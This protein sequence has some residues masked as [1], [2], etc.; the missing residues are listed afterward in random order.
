WLEDA[1]NPAVEDWLVQ[2]HQ[3]CEDYVGRD[4]AEWQ[5]VRDYVKKLPLYETDYFALAIAGDRCVY[6]MQ[7]PG[8]EQVNIYML[9]LAGGEPRLLIDPKTDIV[10]TGW[11]IQE[12]CL[13]ISPCG[14]YLAF[15]TNH[16]GSDI[17][18]FRIFDMQEKQLLDDRISGLVSAPVSWKAD[19]SGFYYGAFR[20]L[21]GE[22]PTADGLYFH[23]LGRDE[24]KDVCLLE[25]T[26]AEQADYLAIMP[27]VIPGGDKIL[28]MR[29]SYRHLAAGLWLMSPDHDDPVQVLF[30]DYEAD[31]SVVGV[32]GGQL[33]LSTTWDA[34]KGRILSI[35]LAAPAR[36]NW[37]EIIAPQALS[38]AKSF[39]GVLDNRCCLCGDRLLVTY[40]CDAKHRVV[41]FDLEGQEVG[42]VPLGGPATVIGLR[43]C[44]GSQYILSI[45]SFLEPLSL[46]QMDMGNEEKK[47]LVN[48]KLQDDLKDIE[49]QQ[50]FYQAD[51]GQK[52]PLY[53][54]GRDI[55]DR[56]EPKPV[57]LY[58]YGG[59][60][61]AITPVFNPDV[62]LWLNM[63]GTYALANIRGGGEYG[64]DWHEAAR[65]IKRNVSFNDFRAAADY[66]TSE[67][68]TDRDHLAI[69]GLS[70][71]G[72]LVGASVV[73]YP[74]K[75]AAAIAEVPLLD[76]IQMVQHA[77]AEVLCKE[78]GDLTHDPDV[79]DTVLKYSPVQNVRN[80]VDYPAVMTVPAREAHTAPPVQSWKFIAALQNHNPQGRPALLNMVS[81]EGHT[82]W[83][84]DNMATAMADE[85]MFLRRTVIDVKPFGKA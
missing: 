19:S 83:S 79:L 6:A 40:M 61:Q 44:S 27:W 85:M 57:L 54:I 60:D 24:T 42:E 22:S 78:Y 70:N 74:E 7:A 80:D 2:Q 18:D 65:G 73:L 16:N 39:P 33:Y 12:G 50:V 77:G 26:E 21:L 35:P 13:E 58:G 68:I 82:N 14:R 48:F 81:G 17:S 5:T 37:R 69:R 47:P 38:I 36:E 20:S 72:L 1:T 84:T 25:L 31:F 71:G 3:L 9:T 4:K 59:F 11:R 23:T 15:A 53:L 32:S 43:P 66:L 30:E 49:V 46:F 52:I 45:T 56:C 64:K 34:E 28:V 75:W 55:D 76:L 10:E 62:I 63:G 51:D 29:Y 8:D 41:I 67:G